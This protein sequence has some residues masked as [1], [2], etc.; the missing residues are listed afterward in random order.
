MTDRRKEMETYIIKR[1][2]NKDYEGAAKAHI[3]NIL[4]ESTYETDCYAQLIFVEGRGFY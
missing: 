4:W 1:K 3:D 2:Q